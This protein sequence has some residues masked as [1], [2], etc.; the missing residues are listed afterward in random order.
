MAGS[1]RRID[2]VTGQRVAAGATPIACTGRFA[3]EFKALQ[4]GRQRAFPVF[5][6]A[7]CGTGSVFRERR[8]EAQR[9]RR[10]RRARRPFGTRGASMSRFRIRPP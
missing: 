7:A 2:D 10:D 3:V 5:A 8:R 9:R 6:C 4:R 1:R